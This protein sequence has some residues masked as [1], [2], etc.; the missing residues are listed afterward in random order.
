MRCFSFFFFFYHS[1]VEKD[2]ETN[3]EDYAYL[4]PDGMTRPAKRN[5]PCIWLRQPWPVIVARK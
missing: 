1:Y 4:C 3:K 2:V 5:N